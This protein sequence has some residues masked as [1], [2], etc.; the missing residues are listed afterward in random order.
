M[1]KALSRL[2]SWLGT[3]L[4]LAVVVVC[5]PLTLPRVLGWDVYAIVSGSMEPEIPT[6]SLVYAAPAEAE[7]I[8]PGDVI[9]FVGGQGESTVITHRVVE[10]HEQ[11]EEFVTRGDANADNDVTPIPYRNLIGKMKAHV[12]VLG[13]FLPVISTL[14]GK[15]YLIGILAAGVLLRVVGGRI[16]N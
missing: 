7:K 16:Q 6:G 11:D 8:V 15:L 5:L 4:I 1:K 10:N 3:L 13:L 2:T 12:P 9:V 14:R